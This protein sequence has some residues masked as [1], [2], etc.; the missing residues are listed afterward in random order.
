MPSIVADSK[1]WGDMFGAAQMRALFT[2]VAM[3]RRYLYIEAALARL[4]DPANYPGAAPEMTR[5]LLARR[6]K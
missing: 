3:V 6:R 5:R 1:L 4:V 2:G